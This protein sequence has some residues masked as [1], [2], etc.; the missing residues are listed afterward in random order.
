MIYKKPAR[1]QGRKKSVF[2]ESIS[3]V[4][5]RSEMSHQKNLLYVENARAMGK[6][7]KRWQQYYN[8]LLEFISEKIKLKVIARVA[9]VNQLDGQQRL[10]NCRQC[11][12]WKMP[13]GVENKNTSVRLCTN[14]KTFAGVFSFKPH[15]FPASEAAEMA[16]KQ[17]FYTTKHQSC[18]YGSRE[19]KIKG[20]SKL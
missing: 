20:L 19:Q 11:V 7:D 1:A 14:P 8:S 12:F 17:K 18:S 10:P 16:L 5:I 15:D 3:V 9:T 4:D 6:H 13:E 2:Q